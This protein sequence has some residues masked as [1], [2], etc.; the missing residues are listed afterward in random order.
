MIYRKN[1]EI[2]HHISFS[3][4]IQQQSHAHVFALLPPREN[5]PEPHTLGFG[6]SVAAHLVLVWFLASG[7]GDAVLQPPSH[8]ASQSIILTA[9]EYLL[10]PDRTGQRNEDT[11]AQWSSTRLGTPMVAP[12]DQY[13]QD[14]RAIGMRVPDTT[15]R[16][17]PRPLVE[18][19]AAQNAYTLLDVDSSAVRDPSSAVPVYPPLLE[20][21]GIEGVAVVRFV[22]D[23]T[24]RADLATFRL[25]E[26]NHALFAAAV[27]DAL[28]AMKFRPATVG[29]AKVR[30]LV[31]IPFGFKILR[32][33]ANAGRRP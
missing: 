7:R 10:P 33:D 21:Q 14:R 12:P 3:C 5:R 26:T 27:R 19:A 4:I 9:L 16:S 28:P 32:R 13:A 18:E 30:Q 31:E 2:K 20:K 23:T 29:P 25:V 24:G 6:V 17:A 15:D 1:I 22:V 8:A 11:R